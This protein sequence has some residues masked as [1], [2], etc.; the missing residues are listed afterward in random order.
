M[1]LDR[2]YQTYKDRADFYVVYI[3]EAHPGVHVPVV[4]NGV[5]S[6]VAFDATDSAAERKRRAGLFRETHRL[7]MP[8]LIAPDEDALEDVYDPWPTRVM[9]ID[10]DG[11]IAFNAGMELL[12]ATKSVHMDLNMSRIDSWMQQHFLRPA[13]AK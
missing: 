10:P 8:V 9:V 13:L 2:L 11:R 7:T 12:R 5:C 4:E 1:H 3:N 6:T